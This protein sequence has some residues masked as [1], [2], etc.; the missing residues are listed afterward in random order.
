L[1]SEGSEVFEGF[2]NLEK[3]ERE[4]YLAGVCFLKTKTDKFKDH[5]AVLNGGEI[6]C[7]RD[8]QDTK[9]RVMHS[10]AGT[11]VKDL[12]AEKDPDSDKQFYP[13]KIVLPPNKS[14]ILYFDS[15]DSQRMW[16]DKLQSTIGF[17]AV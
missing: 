13:V 1:L 15:L 5:W 2:G 8:K 4:N 3:F 14:R 17:S 7:F 11:F 6:F 12:P 16:V 10:L 9:F